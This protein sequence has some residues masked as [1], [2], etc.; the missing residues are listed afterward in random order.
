MQPPT[1]PL[2]QGVMQDTYSDRLD[3]MACCKG[4]YSL[5]NRILS[6]WVPASERA[7]LGLADVAALGAATSGSSTNATNSSK[8]VWQYTLWPYDRPESKGQVKGVSIRLEDG[9]VLVLG[10]R[11]ETLHSQ[12]VR[13]SQKQLIT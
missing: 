13:G 11:C 12:L 1:S 5:H 4:D 2:G 10:Y 3:M 7:L 8:V 9:K 6:G